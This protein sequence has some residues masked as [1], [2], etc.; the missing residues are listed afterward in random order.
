[1]ASLAVS[2][3]HRQRRFVGT[4]MIIAQPKEMPRSWTARGARHRASSCDRPRARPV[5]RIVSHS[6]TGPAWDIRPRPSADTATRV[7]RALFFTAKV[8]STR[9]GQD[10]RQ[11]QSSQVKRHFSCNRAV[12]AHPRRKPEVSS[13]ASCIQCGRTDAPS[14]LAHRSRSGLF[15]CRPPARP[16]PASTAS[17][18]ATCGAG[19]GKVGRRSPLYSGQ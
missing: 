10:S 14:G 15:G 8:P 3:S 9:C 7:P 16:R 5:T 12:D 4:T 2:S 1:M 13:R 19:R 17:W 6:R 18:T 11:A